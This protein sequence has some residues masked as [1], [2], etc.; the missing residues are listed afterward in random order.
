MKTNVYIDGFN[1]Y[2]GWLD[3]SKLCSLLLPYHQ[4][5]RI[6][7]FTARVTSRPD[8]PLQPQRQE[9]YLR[10]LRT[11]PN[12]SIHFGHFLSST[13]RMPL[14]HPPVNGPRTVEVI[15]TEGKGSDVNIAT[16][17]LVDAFNKDCE[18]SVLLSNDSDL[19]TPIE[20]VRINWT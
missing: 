11:I 1:L 19:K 4:I 13:V 5:N 15:K 20:F 18:M 6:R 16:Y 2:Y 17:M 12:L 7:Y 10:A 9:N 3:V 14:A 8:D